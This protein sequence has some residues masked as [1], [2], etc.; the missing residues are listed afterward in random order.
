MMKFFDARVPV[1]INT[2]QAIYSR[3]QA[4]VVL[5]DF[6]ERNDPKDFAVMETGS[7]NKNSKYL[8]GNFTCSSGNY[9]VYI[10]MRAK[11]NNYLLEEIRFNKE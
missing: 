1:T 11:D 8:I 2:N 10:L 5:K 7:P 9:S 3:N 6:F 4:E